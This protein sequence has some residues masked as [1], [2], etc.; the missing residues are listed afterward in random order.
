VAWAAIGSAGLFFSLKLPL[1]GALSAVAPFPLIVQRLKSGLG[2]GLSAALVSAALISVAFS[3]AYGLG[4]LVTLALPGL[5]L[6]EAV[7]RGRGMRRA[8]VWAFAALAAEIG[9]GLFV[10]GPRMAELWFYQPLEQLRSPQFLGEMRGSGLPPERVEDWAEQSKALQS[11]IEVVYPAAFL[12]L[13]ALLVLAN[14]WLLRAYLARR[15]PGWLEGGEFEGMR[16]P[17]GIALPFVAAGAAVTV[18]TLRPLAYNVLL[19]LAFFFA[20]QGLAVVAYYVH[21]LATAALLRGV[22][23]ALV[24]VNP[25]APQI[26]AVVGLFDLWFDFRRWATPPPEEE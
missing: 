26:L 8:C 18:P 15:D 14:A 17:L 4:Y 11:A 25:W 22:V 6:S 1:L 7:V 13:G 16:W 21:R 20:I 19:V 23:L 24:L 3:P 5:L 2:A 12:I 10:A 9:L